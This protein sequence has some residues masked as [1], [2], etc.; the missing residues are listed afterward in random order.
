MHWL[1]TL[2]VALFRFLN[3]KLVN[4]FFDQ[5]M[6]FVSG[7]DTATRIF[8]PLLAVLAFVLI[9]R[10]SPRGAVCVVVL[11]LGIALTDG[12]VIRNIKHA[13]G[14]PR[15][16]MT[17]PETHR[18]GELDAAVESAVRAST[19]KPG[20]K[21][22]ATSMPSGH[23]ANWFAATMIAFL[24]YRRSLWLMLPMAILVSFSR[25][26]NG[27]HYPADVLAGSI[28]GAGSGAA[29]VLCLNAL[30]QWGGAKWFPLWY[31]EMPSLL[32]RPQSASSSEVE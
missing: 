15:P 23:A 31:R 27:V 18:P 20:V 6:P 4:P 19:G 2:D 14:R 32:A 12:F 21:W 8:Y 30:W 16:F 22:N 29:T 13:I 17:L 1:E 11:I 7:T 28:L 26:Y 3:L 24:Y 9:R 25:I 10:S 5:L